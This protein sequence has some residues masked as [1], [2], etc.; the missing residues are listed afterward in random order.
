MP[1]SYGRSIASE[2]APLPPQRRDPTVAPSSNRWL[3]AFAKAHLI[4][5]RQQRLSIYGWERIADKLGG[6]ETVAVVGN[7]GYLADLTQG[8]LIDDHQ[9]VIRL[10][11]F[12]TVGFGRAVG[13]RCD[14]LFTSFFKDISFDRP[15]LSSVDHVVSSV[16]NNLYKSDRAHLHHRHGEHITA[17]MEELGRHEVYVPSSEV[18]RDACARCGAVPST[19]FMAIEFVLRNFRFRSVFVTG[20]SFFQGREHYFDGVSSP[21]PRHDFN[22]ERLVV[23]DLL[24]PLIA[25]GNVRVDAVMARLLR[26]PAV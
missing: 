21:R 12:R 17:G 6:V 5:R 2:T 25:G 9:L 22:R 26:V 24:S 18:F 14:I 11:N 13:E 8:S 4:T 10:N 19:G 3:P 20:F 7:A 15:E 1:H 23:A 16:P